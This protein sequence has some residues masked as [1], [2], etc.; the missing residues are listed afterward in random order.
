VRIIK[1]AKTMCLAMVNFEKSEYWISLCGSIA[2]IQ[3]RPASVILSETKKY[4][5]H[6]SEKSRR[7]HPPEFAT[8]NYALNSSA[9]HKTTPPCVVKVW[10]GRRLGRLNRLKP[11]LKGRSRRFRRSFAAIARSARQ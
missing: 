10:T 4:S 2:L 3:P 9:G 6:H 5:V 7:S 11:C 1:T 8:T